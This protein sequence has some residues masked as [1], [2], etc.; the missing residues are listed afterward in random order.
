MGGKEKFATKLDSLF[1]VSSELEGE[2]APDDITGL[3][4]QYA[5]GNEPSHHVAYLYHFTDQAEKTQFYVDKIL[6]ELYEPA[7]AGVSGNE[8][9]GAMSAWYVLNALGFYQVC[10]GKPIYHIGRPLVDY[11]II[12]L[13]NGNKFNIIVENN[14]PNNKYVK[15]VT[16]NG[17]ALEEW[18]FSHEELT[19]GGELKFVMQSK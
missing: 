13:P 15:S 18:T 3:I 14:S 17:K 12:Q 8:D 10:P 5:H 6:R 1:T 4:G 11:A 7:P 9:C 19:E 2:H 16:L